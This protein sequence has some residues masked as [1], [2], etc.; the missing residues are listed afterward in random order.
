M[1]FMDLAMET[2]KPGTHHVRRSL[3]PLRPLLWWFIFVLVLYAI[4]THQRL[5]DETRLSFTISMQGESIFA[6]AM[7]D[8]KPVRSGQRISLGSHTFSVT[9]SKTKPFT[10]NLFVWYGGEDFGE[11]DLKRAKGVLALTA[12][13]PAREL[14]IQGPEWGVTLMNSSG[15]TETIPTDDY[16]VTARYRYSEDS[17]MIGVFANVTNTFKIAPRF[18]TLELACNQSN[19]TFRLLNQ[20]NQF[21]ESGEFPAT[22]TELPEGTYTLHALHHR[23]EWTESPS[24]WSETTNSLFVEFRYGAAVLLTVPT[25]ASVQTTDG[26]ELGTTPLALT[27]MQPGRWNFNLRLDGYEPAAVSVDVAPNETNTVRANLV[28]RSF[29]SAMRTARQFMDAGEFDKAADAVADALRIEPNDSAAIA[30]RKQARCLG[31]IARAERLGNRGDYIAGEQELERALVALP[32]N[33]KAQQMFADFKQHEPEQR[34][35]MRVEQ[36]GRPKKVFNYIVSQMPDIFYFGTNELKTDKPAGEVKSAIIAQI[37]SNQPPFRITRSDSPADQIFRIEA[38]ETFPGGER[39]C[40]IVVGQSS[41]NE[42]KIL[43]KVAE[44]KKVGFMKQPITSLVGVT[45][46]AYTVINPNQPQMSEKSKEQIAEGVRLVT[47]RIQCAIGD[48]G[49]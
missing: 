12:N 34:E 3:R 7:L 46:L 10:T 48:G 25:G 1:A 4:R 49:K 21:V 11:I 17:K 16:T 33:V 15:L 42:T 27:E 14:T 26:R 41:E 45:P 40:V 37:A 32:D 20:N 44:F 22:I 23:H 5:M 2:S 43:F 29:L 9:H 35:R 24:V 19:A 38:E 8:G 36:L 28:S 31:C 39:R 13:P 47:E 6:L 30:L 18:G